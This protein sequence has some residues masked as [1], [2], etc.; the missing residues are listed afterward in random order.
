MADP[1]YPEHEETRTWYGGPF[2]PDD[3][4]LPRITDNLAA[5]QPPRKFK[6][7]APNAKQSS[8]TVYFSS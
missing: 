3:L 6:D 2:D 4:D 7:T 5:I 8:L 1:N